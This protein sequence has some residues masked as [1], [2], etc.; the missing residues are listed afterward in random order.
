LSPEEVECQLDLKQIV[1]HGDLA[2]DQVW[3][4]Q[5]WWLTHSEVMG[6]QSK[7]SVTGVQEFAL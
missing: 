5:Q 7:E 1:E 3:I 6:N 2:L 4:V